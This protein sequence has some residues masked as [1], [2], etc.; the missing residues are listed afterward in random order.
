MCNT[1]RLINFRESAAAGLYRKAA[2]LGHIGA[3]YNLGLMLEQGVGVEQDHVEAARLFEI[4]AAKGY[5]LH[6][7]DPCLI[8]YVNTLP[9]LLDLPCVPRNDG[10]IVDASLLWACE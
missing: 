4:A 6:T 10:T 7:F 9:C 1:G 3:H 2:E 8:S 5:L